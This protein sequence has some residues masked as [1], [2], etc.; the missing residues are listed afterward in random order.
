MGTSSSAKPLLLR[1]FNGQYPTNA[2]N[3]DSLKRY[4]KVDEKVRG[5]RFSLASFVC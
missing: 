1:A 3:Q 5:E 4:K 2:G